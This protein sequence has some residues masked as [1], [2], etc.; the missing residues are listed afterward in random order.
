M[1]VGG[2]DRLSLGGRTTR[3]RMRWPGW[4]GGL[5]GGTVD[6]AAA[7]ALTDGHPAARARPRSLTPS[8]PVGTAAARVGSGGPGT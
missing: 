7:Q 4:S 5:Q 2:R 8:L 6:H 1:G 3:G